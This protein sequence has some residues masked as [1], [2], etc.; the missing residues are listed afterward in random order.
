MNKLELSNFKGFKDVFT[1]SLAGNNALIFGENGSGK[2]SV[3]E[4]IKLLFFEQRIFREN[5]DSN[6]IDEQRQNAQNEILEEYRNDLNQRFSLK[7]DDNI[8]LS[9]IQPNNYNVFLICYKDIDA[10]DNLDF[11][12]IA[13]NA[14]LS[15]INRFTNWCDYDIKVMVKDE[16]NKILKEFFF[17]NDIQIDISATGRFTIEKLG[18]IS[19]KY[20][21]LS[22]YF[23][24]ATLHL[25][26]MIG[27]IEIIGL[28][29]DTNKPKLLVLDDCFNSLDMGNRTFMGKYLM[30]KTGDMQVIVLTHNIGF[31]D[32]FKF[33]TKQQASNWIYK[34]ICLIN[35]TFKLLPD[36]DKTIDQFKVELS[37]KTNE[38]KGNAIRQR[39]EVDIYKI[40][41]LSSTG[42]QEKTNELLD[43][44]A[45][46][47]DKVY[48]SVNNGNVK[49]IYDLVQEIRG[50]CGAGIHTPKDLAKNIGNKIKE[51]NK[52]DF[53]NEI[54]DDL[55]DLGLLQKVTLHQSSHG[56]LN[57]RAPITT[58]EIET[59]LVLLERIERWIDKAS[60]N[61]N[62]IIGPY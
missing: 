56:H 6:V 52:H 50:L 22:K 33:I 55:N 42:I 61:F 62:N 14:Y 12:Q 48:L 1:I 51:F 2:S 15:N 4:G 13:N 7:M 38:Q 36:D 35:K 27:L 16:I 10:N 49:T 39:F 29:Q 40:A 17:I 41:M 44:F 53:L 59:S 37:T 46:G 26:R 58:N 47:H 43:L 57:R 34:Q 23:N 11:E 18:L 30:K 19:A 9:N 28:F 20:E 24:E 5:I 54:R 31:Y 8:D 32:L 60:T 25:I 45:S 21:N 3:F